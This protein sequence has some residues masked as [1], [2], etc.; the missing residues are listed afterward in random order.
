V[1]VHAVVGD[2]HQH[3]SLLPRA[4]GRRLVA[5]LGST[6]GNFDV[7]ERA[8]FFR[9]LRRALGR[10]DALL[11]GADLI[12]DRRRLDAAYNDA[13]GVTA[14]FNLNLLARINRELA[15][16]FDLKAFEH[17]AVYNPREGRIE[18]HLKSACR[19]SASVLGRRVRFEAGERIHTENSYKYTIGQFHELARSAGWKPGR[20]WTDRADLFSVHELHG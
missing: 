2:F 20:V 8:P 19:Q 15:G 13:A 12:K 11:L 10:G 3:V 16:T 6:I 7:T 5:F 1:S 9:G 17:E 18:M 4:G 14:A